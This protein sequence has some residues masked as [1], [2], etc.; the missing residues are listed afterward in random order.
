MSTRPSPIDGVPM[1]K[2]RRYGV[3]MDICTRTGGVWLDPGELERIIAYV[4]GDA[5]SRR[6]RD[7]DV[8]EFGYPDDADR[9]RRRRQHDL[10][11]RARLSDDFDV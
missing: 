2:V 5:P 6:P 3:E 1:R 10:H 11:A 9:V 4:Q 7:E 8:A